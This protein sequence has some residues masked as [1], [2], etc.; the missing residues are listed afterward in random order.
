MYYT[1][2]VEFWTTKREMGDDFEDGDKVEDMSGYEK[3][4]VQHA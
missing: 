3:S 4:A 2:M 1:M